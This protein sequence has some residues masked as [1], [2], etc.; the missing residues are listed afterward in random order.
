M[1]KELLA[2][3]R[4]LGR[5]TLNTMDG[6]ISY[7]DIQIDRNTFMQSCTT[8]GQS[9]R[10]SEKEYAILE[11]MIANKNQILTREQF[12]VKIWGFENDA[13]Y[14]NVEVYMSFT[15]KKLNFVG[16]KIEIKAIR[17]MGYELRCEHV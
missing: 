8:S 5:R 9:V 4:A 11:Y 3:V 17:G 10:L 13:E 12:A 6:I 16:A 1:T 15:R 14:N 2:R 7:G